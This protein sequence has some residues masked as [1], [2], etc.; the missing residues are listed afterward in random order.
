MAAAPA[1]D[2]MVDD[3][4]LVAVG[5]PHAGFVAGGE[6]GH[7]GG[8]DGGGEVHGAAVVA[9]E[10][11]GVGE[12]GGAFARGELAAEVEDGAEL[13]GAGMGGPGA[14]PALGGEW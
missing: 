3:A 5:E 9:E 14:A 4:V 7:A 12:D 8:L 11:P 10:E 1:L 6:D 13:G 2:L